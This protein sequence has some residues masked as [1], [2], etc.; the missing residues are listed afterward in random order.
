MA[1]VICRAGMCQCTK[2]IS[3]RTGPEVSPDVAL[4]TPVDAHHLSLV[5]MLPSLVTWIG[6]TCGRQAKGTTCPVGSLFKGLLRMTM[7]WASG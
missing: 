6:Y 3:P 5:H 7:R 1:R 4:A 2:S